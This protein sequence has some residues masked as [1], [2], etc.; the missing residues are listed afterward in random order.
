MGDERG[1]INLMNEDVQNGHYNLALW[2]WRFRDNPSGVGRIWVAESSTEIE[3]HYAVIPVRIKLGQS[4][5]PCAQSLDT[6][7]ARRFRGLGIFATL[8]KK[9]YDDCDD[10]GISIMYGFPNEASYAGFVDKL[11][12]V[13]PFS[14]TKLLRILDADAFK[15]EIKGRMRRI[16]FKTAGALFRVWNRNPL[17]DKLKLNREYE[18]QETETIG[19]EFDSLWERV[20][21]QYFDIVER[22]SNYL[23]WR[24]LKHPNAKYSVY[25]ARRGGELLGYAVTRQDE[26][27]EVGS[28]VDCF[29]AKDDRVTLRT[30]LVRAIKDF[31][32]SNRALI[33]TAT[34]NHMPI[35]NEL[36]KFGFFG[37]EKL[38]FI[39][40]GRKGKLS[41]D[42]ANL[43]ADNWF[44][45]LG[46]ADVG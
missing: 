24:Y 46:D 42:S 14:L 21:P 35:Y 28:I 3:G 37:Y 43:R 19:S 17:E 36:R 16:G 10:L 40:R 38:P 23:Q 25:T 6:R 8:A 33:I 32:N 22:S 34:L 1:I 30:L 9:T 2:S 20:S 15:G 7:T 12:W 4:I 5:L 13:H 31:I 44:L 26:A 11:N 45:M 39:L 27:S 18:V 29:V 41:H